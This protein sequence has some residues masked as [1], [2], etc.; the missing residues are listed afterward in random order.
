MKNS[1]QN[2]ASQILESL[3]NDIIQGEYSPRQKLHIKTLK[4]RYN[5]GTSPLREEIGRASCR[6]RV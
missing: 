4:D 5:V 6:E 1:R 3:T 2:T